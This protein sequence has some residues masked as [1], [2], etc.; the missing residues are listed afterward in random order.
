MN[1]VI[2]KIFWAGLLILVII[3][4]I[5]LYILVSTS[6]QIFFQED[7]ISKKQTALLLGAKVYKNGRLSQ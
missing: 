3:I 2:K 4:L 7:A 1:K 6:G 5:N